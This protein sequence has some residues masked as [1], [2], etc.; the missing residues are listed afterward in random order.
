M[1]KIKVLLIPL[2]LFFIISLISFNKSQETFPKVEELKDV[3]ADYIVVN[4]WASYDAKSLDRTIELSSV[5][6][7]CQKQL[8]DKGVSFQAV[9]ISL[10]NYNSVYQKTLEHNELEYSKFINISEGFKSPIA[11]SLGLKDYENYLLDKNGKIL[12][13]NFSAGELQEYLLNL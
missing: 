9:A 11:K 1:N 13:R 5:L 4:F 6:K 12:I 3:E 7:S 8:D 2:F 10:D